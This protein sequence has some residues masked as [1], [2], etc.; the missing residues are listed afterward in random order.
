M[1][2]EKLSRRAILLDTVPYINIPKIVEKDRPIIHYK[3]S[4]GLSL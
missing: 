4:N 1:K 2:L 3:N